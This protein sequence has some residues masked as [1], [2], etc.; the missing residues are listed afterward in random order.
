[1]KKENVLFGVIGLMVGVIAGF[2]FANSI[3]QQSS[4]PPTPANVAGTDM[5][6][7]SNIPPGHPDIGGAQGGMQPDTLAAIEKAKQ[8]PDDF[9][10]QFKAAELYYQIGR[11]EEALP[12]LIQAN[13]LKPDDRDVMI[14]LGN[15]HFDADKYDD[16][17]KWYTSALAKKEDVGVR[18]DLGLTH[19]FRQPPNYDRAI[20]E[21]KRSLATDPN[22]IQTLQNLTVAYTKKNDAAAA[23]ETLSKL[24]AVDPTN[25]ALAKLRE[26]VGKIQ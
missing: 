2:M 16:A 20:Q 23:K 26:E 8:A 17:E 6:S 18:T 22:H 21:F 10:A 4:A 13:K 14:Q 12:F 1:M 11:F 5:R 15:A 25:A 7:N 9:D 3:N 19:V 24:E